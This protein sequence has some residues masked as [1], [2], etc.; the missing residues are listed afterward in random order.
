MGSDADRVSKSG[1]YFLC[2]DR[3]IEMAIAFL[4]AFRLYNPNLSLCL[5]PYRDDDIS[6]LRSLAGPY[7]FSIFSDPD[8]LAACD[9]IGARIKQKDHRFRKLAIWEGDF[10]DFIYLDVDNIVLEDLSPLFDLLDTYQFVV[11]DSKMAGNIQ[12]VWKDSISLREKIGSDRVQY[13]ANTSFIASKKGAL[14][15]NDIETQI[16]LIDDLVPHMQLSCGEQ[17]LLNLLITSPEKKTTSLTEL[18]DMGANVGIGYW[19]GNGRKPELKAQ[20]YDKGRLKLQGTSNRIIFIHW[21]GLWHARRIDRF[22]YGILGLCGLAH[23]GMRVTKLFF[24]H[25]RLWLYY[26]HLRP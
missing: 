18:N 14:S 22:V 19:A 20:I 8:V 6:Q 12:W 11:C 10:D 26:R 3:L 5:I 21:S 9:E 15:L 23:R 25:K 13:A 24:P 16:D 2:N 1:V 17:P 4:N 7:N